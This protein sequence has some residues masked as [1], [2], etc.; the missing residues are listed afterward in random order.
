MEIEKR[1]MMKIK[2]LN[3][4]EEQRLLNEINKRKLHVVGQ[5]GN[6]LL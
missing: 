6:L 4:I 2:K 3:E 1:K 5:K